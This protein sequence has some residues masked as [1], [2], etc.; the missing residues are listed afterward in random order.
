MCPA[1]VEFFPSH[2][3]CRARPA[4]LCALYFLAELVPARRGRVQ[5][6]QFVVLPCTRAN[7]SIWPVVV[8]QLLTALIVSSSR[9]DASPYVTSLT[10]VHAD[11]R[12]PR[13]C[14]EAS[15]WSMFKWSA[16]GQNKNHRRLCGV[17]VNMER[18]QEL[19]MEEKV[20]LRAILVSCSVEDFNRRLSSFPP[21]LNQVDNGEPNHYFY[22]GFYDREIRR[23]V[24]VGS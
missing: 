17:L 3:Y 5:L 4:P 19:W 23:L 20:K 9:L 12:I 15:L 10:C 14:R 18:F 2:A 1:P 11:K 16:K 21:T 22:Y 24:C 13:R 6:S 7:S 8:L